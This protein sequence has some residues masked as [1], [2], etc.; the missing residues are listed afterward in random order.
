[1]AYRGAGESARANFTNFPLQGLWGVTE[2]PLD[3]PLSPR[4]NE[5]KQ[6]YRSP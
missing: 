4:R 6:V 3:R 5:R 2:L 1:M